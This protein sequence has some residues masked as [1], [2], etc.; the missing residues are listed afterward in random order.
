MFGTT[1]CLENFEGAS[2][3]TLYASYPLREVLTKTNTITQYI[4][5]KMLYCLCICLSVR[6]QNVMHVTCIN[7]SELDE[8]IY[9][10]LLLIDRYGR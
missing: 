7:T 9:F 8:G 2:T 4:L 6:H 3:N 10:N 1:E 5:I